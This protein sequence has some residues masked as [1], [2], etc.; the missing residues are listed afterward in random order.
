MD[1]NEPKRVAQR[2][3]DVAKKAEVKVEKVAAKAE[4]KVDKA[5]DVLEKKKAPTYQ[6]ALQNRHIQMIAIGGAIGTGLFLGAGGRL[7]KAGPSLAIIYLLCGIL[8]FFILRALGEMIMYRPA[9]GSFVSYAREFI[10]EHGAFAVG[11]MYFVNWACTGIVDATAVATYLRYWN[12]GTESTQ[13]V[14]ALIALLLVTAINFMGVKYFGEFEFWFAIIKVAALVI[15]LLVAVWVLGTG[16]VMDG[17]RPGPHLISEH[18]GWFPHGVM[19]AIVLSQGVIFAYA[20]IELV[21]ITAGEAENARAVIPKAINSVIWRILIF[22]VGAVVLLTMVLPWSAYSADTSPFVTF[23][24]KLGIPGT[25]GIMNFVIL[26][27]AMSSLNSGIYAN[28]RTLRDLGLSRSAPAMTAKMS[29][30]GVPT[31]AILFTLCFSLVGIFINYVAPGEAF[32]IVLNFASV[33]IIFIWASIL[34]THL[35]FRKRVDAGLLPRQSFSMPGAPVTDYI[36]LAF[37]A[38]VFVL[39]AFDHPVGTWTVALTPVLFGVLALYW[40]R[41]K[42]RIVEHDEGYED[43][44]THETQGT[45]Q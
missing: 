33:A 35:I 17:N 24:D 36:C 22:Y 31:G 25:A 39:M 29:P 21:G 18:G 14:A 4:R 2:A 16:H 38:G 8:G 7:Q 13:W 6:K 41:I 40:F 12:V 45:L 15:F 37:L 43:V 28:G 23:F 3:A 5:T 19:P 27:A 26:T 30:R 34:V 42:D 32:E 11:W 20:A 9:S 44:A 10:G 1:N